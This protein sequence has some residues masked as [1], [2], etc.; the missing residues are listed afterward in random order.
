[1][2]TWKWR[3]RKPWQH[4][5]QDS[6]VNQDKPQ[7][8]K[9]AC[10]PRNQECYPVDSDDRSYISISSK[11][12]VTETQR[13][14]MRMDKRTDRIS[15][16]EV[17]FPPPPPIVFITQFTTAD[18]DQES[19]QYNISWLAAYL[20]NFNTWHFDFLFKSSFQIPKC[21]VFKTKQ[22]KTMT[23]LSY[24]TVTNAMPLNPLLRAWGRNA[25]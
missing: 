11:F 18:E 14:N 17:T 3:K 1:M 7:S 4:F 15:T 5:P 24:E 6:E 13:W 12:T 25:N 23:Y 9:M 16:H 2:V 20:I 21:Q 8:G 22:N 10:G 19:R